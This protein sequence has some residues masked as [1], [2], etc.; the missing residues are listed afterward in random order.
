M[1][2]DRG[3]SDSAI[4]AV[5]PTNNAWQP[6]AELVEPRRGFS[7]TQASKA[8]TGRLKKFI[9]KGAIHLVDSQVGMSVDM[10]QR[11]LPATVVIFKYV[12]SQSTP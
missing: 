5:K 9:W 1:M 2:H 11:R 8:R 7:G 10:P 12:R 3:K 6:A 4:V